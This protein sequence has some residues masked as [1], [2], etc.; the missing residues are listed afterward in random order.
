[1]ALGL[2]VKSAAVTLLDQEV[3]DFVRHASPSARVAQRAYA[4]AMNRARCSSSH[5]FLAHAEPVDQAVAQDWP[6]QPRPVAQ[7]S[8][9]GWFD[10]NRMGV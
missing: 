7:S 3:A 9:R 4:K 2:Q 8:W 1:M 6:D 10:E 5:T